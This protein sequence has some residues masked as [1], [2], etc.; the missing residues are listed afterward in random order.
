MLMARIS[1]QEATDLVR[2]CLEDGEV[3]YGKHFREALA[4]EDVTF[5]DAWAVLRGGIIYEEPEHD[6]KTGEWKYRIEGHEPEGKWLVVVL[7]F[8]AV[9]T[10]FLITVFSVDSR[11][12]NE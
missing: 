2:H 4:E 3:R 1:R 12:R 10:T 9:D 5:P 7:S 11:R 6:I 8:K